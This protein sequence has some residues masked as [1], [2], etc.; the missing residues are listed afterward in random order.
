M[1]IERT[2]SHIFRTSLGMVSRKIESKFIYLFFML[3]NRP[4]SL[5]RSVLHYHNEEIH[6]FH[7][8]CKMIKCEQ[9]PM[10]P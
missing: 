4:G 6:H 8:E 5:C 2:A 9:K 3:K 7:Y 1:Q 10:K